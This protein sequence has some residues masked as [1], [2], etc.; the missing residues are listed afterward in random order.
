MGE[1]LTKI[2]VE[3]GNEYPS[4]LFERFHD[5]CIGCMKEL[6]EK[7]VGKAI[8]ATKAESDAEWQPLNTISRI[9]DLL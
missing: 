7:W 2:C 9:D 5:E 3:C 4:D 8:I 6:S 1:R